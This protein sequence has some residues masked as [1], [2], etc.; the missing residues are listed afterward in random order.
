M[1][2]VLQ[3]GDARARGARR[4]AA[5]GV[6]VSFVTGA[7]VLAAPAGAQVPAPA[8][9][10][11]RSDLAVAVQD[12]D[13]SAAESAVDALVA[14]APA[15]I[16]TSAT[17]L[18]NVVRKRGQEGVASKKGRAAIGA[19]DEYIAAKCGFPVLDVTGLDY[20]FEGVTSPLTAGTFVIEFTN[21]APA[22]HHEF[23]LSRADA[24]VDFS[25]K[26]LLASADSSASR[27]IPIGAAFAKPGETDRLVVVLDPGRY[28]YACF[29][30]VET[31]TGD[32]DEHGEHG[33]AEH[34][35]AAEPHWGEG[36]RGEL[37]AV[38]IGGNLPGS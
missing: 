10:Q 30:D 2:E 14:D 29:I 28:V 37:E 22:E 13:D 9:C 21:E 19:V 16:A 18:S 17:T 15:E 26:K 5:I 1:P 38:A 11:A 36:M 24:G 33:A 12:E 4:R 23:V 35:G 7:W 8:V 6:L 31:T 32:A 25:V 3:R 27:L 34:G 20:L